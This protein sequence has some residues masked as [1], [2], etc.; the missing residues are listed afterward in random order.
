MG[1]RAGE[2]KHPLTI[3]TRAI[4]QDTLGG[5][6]VTWTDLAH[7][8]AHIAPLSGRELLAAQAVQ[9]EVTHQITVRYQT[10]FAN[11]KTVA[12]YRAIYKGRIF[13]FG[14]STNQ[15]ERN[16]VVIISATEGLNEG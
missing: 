2:L 4:T 15:D 7:V 8:R 6:A 1:L 3:Q 13:N 11:P 16:R 9:S 5:Q 12:A 10:I 14:P